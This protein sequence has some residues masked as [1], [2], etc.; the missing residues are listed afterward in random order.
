MESPFRTLGV[1]VD[2]AAKVTQYC[3]R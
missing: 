3:P 2:L 1:S